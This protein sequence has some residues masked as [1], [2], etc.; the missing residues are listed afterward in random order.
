MRRLVPALLI[1]VGCAVSLSGCVLLPLLPQTGPQ[2]T[3]FTTDGP[4]A[5]APAGWQDLDPCDP[6]DRWV[7]VE[8]Y[9][10]EEMEAAGLEAECGGTYFDSDVPTYTSVGDSSVS[11]DQ[12]DT[13][14]GQLEAVGYEQNGSTFQRPEP[15]DEPGLVGSFQYDRN[16]DPDGAETIFVVN[17]WTGAQPIQYQ[18]FVDY[19]SPATRALQR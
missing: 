7:Y 8:G 5:N 3:P 2:A 1:A 15:G 17:F 6:S 10:V 13:L 9:P 12:L 11:E 19:E 18:T 14:L 16:T 4:L